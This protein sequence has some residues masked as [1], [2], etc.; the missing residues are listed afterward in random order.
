MLGDREAARDRLLAQLHVVGLG[1]GEVLEQV[2]EGLRRRRSAGRPRSPLWVW[3]R[4]PLGPGLPAAAISGW[5]ARCSAS[6]AGSSAVAIRSMS[7][8]VSAQRRTEPAT[9]TRLAAGCSRSAAASSS[10]IGRTF[11]SSRRPGPSPGSPSR[12]S[13]ARMFSSAFGPRPLTSRILSPSAASFRSSSEADLEL[14]EE[15]AR[16]F[17]AEAGDPGHLDQGRRELRLQLHRGGDLAGLQQRVDL[18]RQRLADA[19]DLGRPPCG[20]QLGDRDRALA[21]RLGGG[22]VGEHP[23]FDGAVELVED[24]QLVQGGGDLGVGHRRRTSIDRA[25]TEPTAEPPGWSCRPTTRPRTSSRFVEAVRDKLP[26]SARVLIVDD[27]SPDGTGEIA[28]RLAAEHED[29]EVLHRPRKE[30]LGPAYI[31]GFR[32]ALAG[33]AELILEMDSDFS[34]DPAY[35]PRLLDAAER[36]DLVIGSRYVRRR[37]GQRLGARCGG[38]SAAAAAPT[39][40]SSS[41]S[42][43][44]T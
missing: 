42:A 4:T 30:G 38:R 11:E 31:A 33:G 23:V 34:H 28:D 39:R 17:R 3:A 16:G 36:A 29:V 26:A 35:L 32:R 19:G 20:G 15:A 24:P 9:S 22:A 44:A 6:A 7:L 37:R 5:A 14:V 21:D 8:Q 13:A 43:S 27:N 1:A 12:S 25:M 10:A 18:F 2:A 40:G 41:G